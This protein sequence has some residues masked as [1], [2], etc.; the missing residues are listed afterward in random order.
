MGKIINEIGNI[1]GNWV[2]N[3][4]SNKKSSNGAKY[5]LCKC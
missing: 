3:K 2:V 5:W 1:Y 4:L